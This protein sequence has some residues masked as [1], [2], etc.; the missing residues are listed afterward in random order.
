MTNEDD[1]EPPIEKPINDEEESAKAEKEA[2]EQF[3]GEMDRL[4]KPEEPIKKEEECDPLTMDCNQMRDH[5]IGLTNKRTQYDS[6]LKSVDETRKIFPNEHLDKAYTDA[7][8]EKKNMDDK[9]YDA[10]EKF[11]VCTKLPLPKS[12]EKSVEKPLEDK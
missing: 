12:E 7:E 6:F 8:K 2:E 4:D 9:I 11:T 1:S 10:F 3:E 5:I